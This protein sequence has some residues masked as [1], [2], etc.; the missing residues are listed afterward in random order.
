K[1][2]MNNPDFIVGT[3]KEEAKLVRLTVADLGFKTSAT[4]DQVFERAQ[5]LGLELCPPDTGPNYRLKYKDQPLGE[6]VRIGMKQITDSDGRPS[7]FSLRRRGDG[8]WLAACW[9][10]PSG[11]WDPGR[12]FVFRFRKVEA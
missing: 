5:A 6:Y 9:A 2:M 7:V 8:L 11:T 12:G 3:N 10:T 1:S 4:T